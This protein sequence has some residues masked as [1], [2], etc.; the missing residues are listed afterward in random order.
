MFQYNGP[1]VGR[2]AKFLI[3][4]IIICQ[5]LL[6]RCPDDIIN[7]VCTQESVLLAKFLVHSNIEFFRREREG[8]LGGATLLDS[9]AQHDAIRRE[10]LNFDIDSVMNTQYLG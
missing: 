9:F 8:G 1:V 2:T 10:I 4:Y 7:P 3:I 6:I 5:R